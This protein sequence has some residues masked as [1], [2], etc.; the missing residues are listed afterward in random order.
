M[1]HP[2][3]GALHTNPIENPPRIFLLLECLK[4][5]AGLIAKEYQSYDTFENQL[6]MMGSLQI[7]VMDICL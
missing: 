7:D 3:N 2:V 5:E 1:G 4:C 6:P